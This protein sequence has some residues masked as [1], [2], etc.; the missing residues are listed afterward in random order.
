MINLLPD[1]TKKQIVAARINI[2]L[3]K[4][5]V[6]TLF[7]AAFLGLVCVVTYFIAIN[8]KSTTTNTATTNVNQ[9]DSA[10]Y[11]AAKTILNKQISSFTAAKNIV[12]QQVSYSSIITTIASALPDGVILSNLSIENSKLGT[13]TTLQLKAKSANLEQKIKENFQNTPMFSS[14]S[15]QS[16]KLDSGDSSG[17]PT[18]IDL[19]IVINKGLA[20]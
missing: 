10:N 4:Y 17:Y 15:I 11:D 8:N 2:N 5:L 19:S 7:S 12:N 3:A 13:P 9:S 1:E 14:V 18:S 6:F 16:S 20:Q